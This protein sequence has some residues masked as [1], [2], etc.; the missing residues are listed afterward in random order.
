LIG[1]NDLLP[2]T[3]TTSFLDATNSNAKNTNNKQE[4]FSL[5]A[6]DYENPQER[7]TA[8]VCCLGR[9]RCTI[10]SNFPETLHLYTSCWITA[11]QE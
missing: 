5:R 3:T 9:G 6:P 7:K 4:K 2:P 11:G 8:A 1:R 10:N